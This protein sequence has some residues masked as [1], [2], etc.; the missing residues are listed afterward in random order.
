[1]DEL[2]VVRVIV[3]IFGVGFKDGDEFSVMPEES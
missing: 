1:M 3:C 2:M